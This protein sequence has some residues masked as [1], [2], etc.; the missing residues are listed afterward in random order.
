MFKLGKWGYDK[1]E[2]NELLN[3]MEKFAPFC[4]ILNFVCRDKFNLNP[5]ELFTLLTVIV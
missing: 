1:C 4:R 3:I 5:L 2:N